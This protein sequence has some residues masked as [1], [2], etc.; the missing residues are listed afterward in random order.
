MS[1][2]KR[3]RRPR[4]IDEY[5]CA[6]PGCEFEG[7]HA[8]QGV[9]HTNEP[10]FVV[11]ERLEKYAEESAQELLRIRR[12]HYPDDAEYIEWLEAHY[13]CAQINWTFTLDECI[14]LRVENARLKLR[15]EKYEKRTDS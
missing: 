1:E 12:E 13:E 4:E 3:E 7:R 15:L 11:N 10:D 14:R 8:Q 6:E 9:C 2:H 5:F